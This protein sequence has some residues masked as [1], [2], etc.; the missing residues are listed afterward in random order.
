MFS[1]HDLPEFCFSMALPKIGGRRECRMLD[2]TRSL[3]CEVKSARK[4][5]TTGTPKQSGIPCTMVLRLIRDLP[6]VRAL[7][8]TVT[9]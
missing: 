5:V 4:Q 3:A 6:G 8:A 2:R 1:R 9:L 7:I